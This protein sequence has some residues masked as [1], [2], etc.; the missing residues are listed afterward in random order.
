MLKSQK[1]MQQPVKNRDEKEAFYYNAI[2]NEAIDDLLGRPDLLIQE[3][4]RNL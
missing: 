1:A 2:K 4:T 3:N